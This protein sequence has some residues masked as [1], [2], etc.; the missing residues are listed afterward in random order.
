LRLSP[1]APAARF[2]RRPT[3]ETAL[4]S[5]R[6]IFRANRPV[7]QVKSLILFFSLKSKNV[8]GVLNDLSIRLM[9]AEV[10]QRG[11]EFWPF[12]FFVRISFFN[13]LDRPLSNPFSTGG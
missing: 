6:L 10:R 5:I 2:F 1:C 4:V 7:N 12:S 3:A 9:D 8:P 11:I 13:T